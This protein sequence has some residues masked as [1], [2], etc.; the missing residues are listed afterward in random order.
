MSALGKATS[1]GIDDDDTQ[2]AADIL[3]VTQQ[4]VV[5]LV[6]RSELTATTTKGGHRRLGLRDVLAYRKKRDER[7]RQALD[8]VEAETEA[9]GGYAK[10]KRG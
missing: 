6:D 10:L 2:Q 7:R 8:E 1:M 9:Y 5:R 3:N 4:Y